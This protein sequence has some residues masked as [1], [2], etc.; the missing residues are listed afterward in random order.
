MNVDKMSMYKVTIDEMSR[1]KMTAL[2]MFV[3][4]MVINDL[5]LVG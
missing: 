5:K 1:D 4:K 2:T 3:H